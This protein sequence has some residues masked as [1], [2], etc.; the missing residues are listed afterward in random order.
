MEKEKNKD[1]LILQVV[2]KIVLGG[3]FALRRMVNLMFSWRMVVPA[4]LLRKRRNAHEDCVG[5]GT[6]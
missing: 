2:A 5:G 1:S 6:K 4:S 3:A